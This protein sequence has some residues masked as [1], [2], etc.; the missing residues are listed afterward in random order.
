[1]PTI[2]E[3]DGG[4]Y[5]ALDQSINAGATV[6]SDNLFARNL[7]IIRV[8]WR[9]KGANTD[10]ELQGSFDGSN[11]FGLQTL[12]AGDNGTIK[13]VCEYIR[14]EATNS[15]SSAENNVVTVFGLN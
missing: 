5:K 9:E 3:Q 8:Y 13:P 12:A 11:W 14:L 6:Q 4:S 15:G 10:A 1:M 2:T 7:D